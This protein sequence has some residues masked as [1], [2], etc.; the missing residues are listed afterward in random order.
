[1]LFPLKYPFPTFVHRTSPET[2]DN[3]AAANVPASTLGRVK[4]FPQ[5]KPELLGDGGGALHGETLGHLISPMGTG[6]KAPGAGLPELAGPGSPGQRGRTWANSKNN[7]SSGVKI[8]VWNTKPQQ[9]I[10][11]TDLVSSEGWKGTGSLFWKLANKQKETSVFPAFILQLNLRVTKWFTW[12]G[13]PLCGRVLT[14][15]WGRDNEIRMSQVFNLKCNHWTETCSHPYDYWCHEK[16]NNQ[17]VAPCG[18]TQLMTFS[19]QNIEPEGRGWRNASNG[20][21]G[22]QSTKFR[23]WWTL[24]HHRQ[25]AK[26]LKREE[27]D[28]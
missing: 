23:T 13:F 16:R 1:M 18:N 22:M 10:K 19:C 12:G 17:C 15:Y 6:R 20:T 21:T 28:L 14:Q 24:W 9:H 3:L 2:R 4:H 27:G 26:K 25:T 5:H 8:R 7:D 11:N